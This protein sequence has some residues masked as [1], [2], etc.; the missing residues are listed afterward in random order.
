MT[1]KEMA[2]IIVEDQISR[3][4]IPA[5][6]KNVVVRGYLKGRGACPPTSTDA[7]RRLVGFIEM[8]TGGAQ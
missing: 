8:Q 7:M 4:V 1:R 5:D 2:N 6:S 3:G